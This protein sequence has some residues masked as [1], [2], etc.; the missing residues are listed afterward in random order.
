MKQKEKKSCLT[1]EDYLI[2]ESS[3][4]APNNI[5]RTCVQTLNAGTHPTI[6]GWELLFLMKVN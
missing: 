6:N 1:S 3:L 5:N 4:T 2:F